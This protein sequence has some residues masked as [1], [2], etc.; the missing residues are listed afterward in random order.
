VDQPA[1]PARRDA[2]ENRAR[3]VSAAQRVFAEAGSSANLDDVARAAGVGSATLY[4][5]FPSKDHLVRAVLDGFYR[6][7]LDVSGE[8]LAAPPA[9]GLQE[10][11]VT[12][13]HEIAVQRGLASHVWG[14][15]APAE[16]LAALRDRTRCLLERAQQAQAVA[17]NVTL[18]DVADVVRAM[19]GIIEIDGSGWRRHLEYVLIGFREGLPAPAEEHL[20]GHKTTVGSPAGKSRRTATPPRS[21]PG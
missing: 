20:S 21:S 11:L 15:L 2:T 12:V 19:R 8:A 4:R 18:D 1:A 9:E 13:G 7:L 14:E 3:I 10:F 16:V 6:R 17:E 5:H